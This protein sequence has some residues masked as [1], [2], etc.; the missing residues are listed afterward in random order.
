M[1][2]SGMSMDIATISTAAIALFSLFV[3][4]CLLLPLWTVRD[5][6]DEARFRFEALDSSRK[7]FAQIFGGAAIIF[8]FAWAFLR[9]T[10]T[11]EQARLQIA[12]DTYVKSAE[13]MAKSDSIAAR[14]AGVYALGSVANARSEYQM[15]VRDTLTAFIRDQ[16]N[17]LSKTPSESPLRADVQAALDVLGRRDLRKDPNWWLDLRYSYLTR[18][19]FRGLPGFQS[20]TFQ[21]ATLLGADFRNVDLSHTVMDHAVMG[22]YVAFAT[23]GAGPWR[24]DLAFDEIDDQRKWNIIANF[25]NATLVDTQFIGANLSGA[26]FK[27]ADLTDTNFKGANLSRVDFRGAKNVD[28][29][30]FSGACADMAPLF[31]ATVQVIIPICPR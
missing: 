19:S 3:A 28:R 16:A 20:A 23:Y 26:H 15:A 27:N 7:T 1:S 18:P 30:N 8:T 5:F 11:L 12:N 6:V 4:I 14:A 29:A 13:L 22:D 31:D 21:D 24:E 17:T 2:I 9:D 10:Q 25:D